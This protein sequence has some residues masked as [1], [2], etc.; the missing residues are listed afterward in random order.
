MSE[1]NQSSR[2]DFLK[3]SAVVAGAA[4][5]AGVVAERMAHAAG[6][7][8]IKV[9]IIGTGGR[10]SG[11]LGQALHTSNSVSLVAAADAFE[12]NVKGAVAR[13]KKQHTGQVSVDD[14]NIFHGFDAYKGVLD[15][16]TDLVILSTPPGFRP[17]HFEAAVDAGKNIFME[18][19]VASDPPGVRRVLAAAKKADAKNL[20]V[21]VGLQRHHQAHYIETIKRIH[22]GIIGDIVLLRVYWNGTRPWVRPRK[23]GMTE[24]EFQMRNWYYF[25]W[26]CGDHIVEQH[27]HNLDVANWVMNGPPASAQGAG[28]R[29]LPYGP[30]QGEIFDHH[31]IEFTYPNGT[32]MLSMCRH[33]QDTWG[34]VSEHAHGTK[35]MADLS[36]GKIYD[37]SGKNVLWQADKGKKGDATADPYQV[38]HNDLFAAIRNNTPYNEAYYGAASTMTAIL[39]RMATYSGKEIAYADALDFGYELMPKK[40]DWQAEPGPKPDKETG[41]YPCAMP[42]KTKVLPDAK[43]I[44][45]LRKE[46]AKTA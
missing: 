44:E 27:I 18:K 43:E 17:M 29:Q 26:V 40:Y 45:K 13:Y 31:M 24:M 30:N 21:G 1:T 16:K 38:E 41:L 5:T 34:S 7:D 8:Q 25:T 35:G 37:M 4:L 3:T 2:R 36:A 9:G 23:E 12:D 14:K 11:A 42:G 32:K 28:G 10:G 33:Q 19:P 22:D 46:G 15:A 6:S 20:K 39:G